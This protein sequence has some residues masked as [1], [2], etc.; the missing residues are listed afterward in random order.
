V[1]PHAVRLRKVTLDKTGRVK[2]A[3]AQNQRVRAE[4]V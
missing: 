1:T 2:A 3:R 4:A